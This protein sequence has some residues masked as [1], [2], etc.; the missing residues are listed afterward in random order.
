M[1]ATN[2]PSAIRIS[3][4][5]DI[6]GAVPSLVGFHPS[7]SLVVICLHGRRKRA[8]LTM[9]VD[10]PGQ[11]HLHECVAELCGRVVQDGADSV[12][13]VCYTGQP[14]ARGRLPRADMVRLLLDELSLHEVGS[15]EA[16]LVRD[17]RWWSYTCTK[18]CCP[19][20]GTPL[21]SRPSD[22]VTEIEARRALSG[23]AVL[24]GR[25]DLQKSVSGPVALRLVALQQRFEETSERL[26]GQVMDQGLEP[27]GEETLA[28]AHT[29]LQRFVGGET[30]IDDDDAVRVVVGLQDKAPRNVLITWG[31]DNR[32]DE[33][34]ALLT[35]LAQRSPDEYCAPI[36]TVLAAVAYQYGRG[37]LAAVALERALQHQPD[38]E[39]ATVLDVALH[40]QVHPKEIR[41]MS[42]RLHRQLS[43]PVA[44]GD[45]RAA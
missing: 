23:A 21:P 39:M 4:P 14:D 37:V 18:S 30:D 13:L 44:G 16:L 28:K 38:Y 12:I 41:A 35:A 25:E 6:A 34:L 8:G 19:R 1:T 45:P 7:E 32:Q 9:R 3:S 11:D 5:S 29:M 27:V 2:D 22:A 40:R 17:G 31:L 15:V 42:R 26:V 36:C 20:E 33:V 10:L 24:P 43:E